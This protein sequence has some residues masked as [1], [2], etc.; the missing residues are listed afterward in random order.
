MSYFSPSG[1]F[2]FKGAKRV[3][4][5]LSE[6][7]KI[8]A[9]NTKES[10][11]FAADNLITIG[12]N[13]GFLKEK[14]FSELANKHFID[15][16]LH[17]SIIWRIHILSWAM[18]H[19]KNLEGDFVEFGCYDGKVAKF[20]I[21]YIGFE[22]CKKLF[23]LYDIFDNPPVGLGPKHSPELYDEVIEDLKDFKFIKII[24]GLLPES[25]VDNHP[26][27]IAFAHID[28]N[29][30]ETEIAVLEMIFDK[31]TKGGIVILDDYG[32]SNFT[33]SYDKEKFFFEDLG[34]KVAELPTGQGVI[35][36][37]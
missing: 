17:S 34:Y 15:D 23:F 5:W 7:G 25:Y 32:F 10:Q 11:I 13:L 19:C 33:E 4:D 18:N 20:L 31:I 8:H 29:S 6:L 24:K 22:Q 1:R 16:D 21:E 35:I 30:A 36:K 27:K 37:R 2:Y 26:D 12:R 28:L 9:I 14:E 3:K